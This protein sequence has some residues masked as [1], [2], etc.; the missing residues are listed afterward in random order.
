MIPIEKSIYRS[1]EWHLHN[2]AE[3]RQAQA[4][5]RDNV[6]NAGGGETDFATRGRSKHPD[7]TALKAISL[8]DSTAA[9]WLDVIDSTFQFFGDAPEAEFASLY[10]GRG[11]TLRSV[12]LSMGCTE[13]TAHYYRD[14]FVL[15]CGMLAAEKRLIRLDKMQERDG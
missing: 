14:N 15:R 5:H 3:M 11:W 4:M 2:V 1:I 9:R 6:F 13:R 12:A 10:Y 8:V 7:P